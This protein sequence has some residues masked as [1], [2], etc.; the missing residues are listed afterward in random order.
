MKPI[1]NELRT[2]KLNVKEV[3]PDD[4]LEIVTVLK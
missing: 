3:I 2:V 4:I 1:Q